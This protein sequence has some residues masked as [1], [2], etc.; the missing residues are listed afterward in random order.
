VCA[1]LERG[2]KRVARS[3]LCVAPSIERGLLTRAHR[4]GLRYDQL[5]LRVMVLKAWHDLFVRGDGSRGTLEARLA[6][7][8]G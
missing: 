6:R 8:A 2:A 3:A 1:L 5:C 4:A 7:V